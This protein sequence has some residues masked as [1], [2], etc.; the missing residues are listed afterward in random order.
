MSRDA[1]TY[2]HL[3]VDNIVR[4]DLVETK[5]LVDTVTQLVGD[6]KDVFLDF[7]S[8]ILQSLPENLK[9]S[10][11]LLQHPIFDSLNERHARWRE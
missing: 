4:T 5:R 7:A 9:T 3:P 10:R 1:E 8:G 6:E 2:C 11:E